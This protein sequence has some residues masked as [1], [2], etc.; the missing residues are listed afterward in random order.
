LWLQTRA[1]VFFF[2]NELKDNREERVEILKGYS[3][4]FDK[5]INDTEKSPFLTQFLPELLLI[6]HFF[7]PRRVK[8]LNDYFEYGCTLEIFNAEKRDEILNDVKGFLN[9]DIRK[10]LVNIHS[11]FCP[12]K[13]NS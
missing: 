1:R 10:A 12:I 5:L 11:R 13:I 4:A 6:N 3:I 7:N 2:F 9:P 8:A